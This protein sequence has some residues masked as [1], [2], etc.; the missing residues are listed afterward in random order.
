MSG[1]ERGHDLSGS[2]LINAI[3]D[4]IVSSSDFKGYQKLS[5]DNIIDMYDLGIKLGMSR[6]WRTTTGIDVHNVWYK[7]ERAQVLH[8]YLSSYYTNDGRYQ[9]YGARSIWA[10]CLVATTISNTN[11][12]N[13]EVC[14]FSSGTNIPIMKIPI[15]NKNA[16]KLKCVVR[17]NEEF[18]RLAVEIPNQLA[19]RDR[20]NMVLPRFD[21]KK[22]L[23]LS[24]K[25]PSWLAISI[26]LS[27]KNG[28]KYVHCPG[29]GYIKV[30]DKENKGY[31]E[32]TSLPDKLE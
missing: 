16:G 9:I 32:I 31:G 25:I 28:Q 7:P 22:K 24:G 8:D 20:K 3:A 4:M 27:Y 6:H 10:S 5:G 18:V 19:P 2:E 13:I 1:L 15:G 30:A 29:I 12:S 11:A 21:V 17:E 26:I 23:L 14:G